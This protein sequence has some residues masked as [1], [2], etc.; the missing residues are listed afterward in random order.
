MTSAPVAFATTYLP[1][2]LLVAAAVGCDCGAAEP[3]PRE[4]AEPAVEQPLER[5]F[6]GLDLLGGLADIAEAA[7]EGRDQ[8]AGDLRCPSAFP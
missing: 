2:L 4:V 1:L 3:T 5:P 8:V 6:V 7:E